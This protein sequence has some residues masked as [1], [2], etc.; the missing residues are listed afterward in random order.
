MRLRWRSVSVW[1]ALMLA[2][3]AFGAPAALAQ[4]HALVR[5]G[6]AQA[7]NFAFMPADV[8]LEADIFT[9][10][11]IDLAIANFGGD[12]RLV[13]AIT[14]GAIDIALGGGPTLAFAV[15]GAP[16]L[17]IAALADRPS[18]IMLVVAKDGPVRTED[19][20]KGRTVSVSTTGSLTYWLVQELSR[21]RGWGS[22]G[23]KIAPLGTTTAQAAA[24]KTRQV[25]GVV[26]ETG[27]VLRLVEEGLGRI[28]VRFGDR[29]PD[30]HSH[31]ILARKG[32][33]D[34]HPDAVRAFL[35]SWFES[36]AYMRE[37]RDESIA[38][39]MRVAGVSKSVATANY[40]ELMPVFNPTGRFDMKALDVLARSFVD[41]GT[42][43]TK[44]DMSK[45][46]T[47]AFL[48]KNS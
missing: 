12:A 41:M 37:H 5:L 36:V 27:T 2:A 40:D 43:P 14:A 8:G 47:E 16:M 45:L 3:S 20:L 1:L 15:K 4:A 10:N 44:P 31:V 48:P 42:L 34:S 9:R 46:Y 26:T 6:K 7:Q 18:T 32:F 33:L 29:V 11:G 19:D 39:A 13:Q 21:S 23:I 28:L 22:D 25:D 24:L 35:K 38:I 17:A 30:F